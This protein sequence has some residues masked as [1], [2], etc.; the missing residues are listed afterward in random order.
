MLAGGLG[1]VA[2]TGEAQRA[3]VQGNTSEPSRAKLGGE[4]PLAALSRVAP[5]YVLP[6]Q[7]QVNGSQLLESHTPPPPPCVDDPAH[8]LFC[9][10]TVE[11]G[12]TLSGIAQR[13][14]MRG[15]EYFSAVEMLALSNKPDV[16]SSDQI[17][18]GQKL[19]L[20]KQTG[21]L[22]TVLVGEAVERDCRL[23]RRHG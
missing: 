11:S 23:L 8:P 18:P 12:D 20:P 1:S 19:R 14:Q 4:N 10:Y 15:N 13:F 5:A 21:I 6:P 7:S 3:E 22:L 16:V 2:L 9:V 17:V